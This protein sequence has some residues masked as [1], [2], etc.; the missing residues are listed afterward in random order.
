MMIHVM[1]KGGNIHGVDH[2]ATAKRRKANKE[3][4]NSRRINRHS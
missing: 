1:R 4:K 3:A 2:A